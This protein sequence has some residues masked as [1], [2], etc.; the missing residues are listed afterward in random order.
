MFFPHPTPVQSKRRSQKTAYSVCGRNNIVLDIST[1]DV[2]GAL[3]HASTFV[4]ESTLCLAMRENSDT[5]H[6]GLDGVGVHDALADAGDEEGRLAALEFVIEVDEEGVER[7]LT[8]VGGRRVVLVLVRDRVDAGGRPRAVNVAAV[9]CAGHVAVDSEP[10]V[11]ATNLA[12]LRLFGNVG[13]DSLPELVVEGLVGDPVEVVCQ[14]AR[15]LSVVADG[16]VGDELDGLCGGDDAGAL[17]GSEDVLD[18]A[19]VGHDGVLEDGCFGRGAERNGVVL[20]GVEDGGVEVW[21]L[22]VGACRRVDDAEALAKV[23]RAVGEDGLV[24]DALAR[25]DGRLVSEVPDLLQSDGVGRGEGVIGVCVGGAGDSED[26]IEDAQQLLV[27]VRARDDD[28]AHALRLHGQAADNVQIAH[29][30][31]ESAQLGSLAADAHLGEEDECIS[32]F[33]ICQ[34]ARDA[35]SQVGALGRRVDACVACLPEV[36]YGGAQVFARLGLDQPGVLREGAQ[37]VDSQFQLLGRCHGADVRYV[38]DR[39]VIAVVGCRQIRWL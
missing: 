23:W 28:L 20:R 34:G 33:G 30:S 12:A 25:L 15:L 32:V 6:D 24:V 29:P 13:A 16:G 22:A 18:Q 1:D 26:G 27:L 35:S 7:R 5:S 19:Q 10:A 39:P 11:D 36:V 2:L 9:L 14:D 17:G 21:R 38:L 37:C 31:T 4:K 3:C 8:S